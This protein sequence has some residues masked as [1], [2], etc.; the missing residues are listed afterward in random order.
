MA[1]AGDDQK[2]ERLV[3]IELDDAAGPRRSAEA[4]KNAPSPYMIF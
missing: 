1:G 2:A 3:K 4:D